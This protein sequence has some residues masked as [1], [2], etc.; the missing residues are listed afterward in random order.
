MVFIRIL[1]LRSP[2]KTQLIVISVL[3]LSASRI[4]QRT[5]ALMMDISAKSAIPISRLCR[6]A[7]GQHSFNKLSFNVFAHFDCHVELLVR[8][9]LGLKQELG[10]PRK[11]HETFH[12][13]TL[14]DRLDAN[15]VTSW[16]HSAGEVIGAAFVII[17]A[18]FNV[19][20]IFEVCSLD[21]FFVLFHYRWQWS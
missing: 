11:H 1:F 12:P 5:A 21:V 4:P 8:I 14:G 17:D 15:V 6:L 7:L 16:I 18:H 2:Q 9:A 19:R 13:I 20:R 3:T 10:L